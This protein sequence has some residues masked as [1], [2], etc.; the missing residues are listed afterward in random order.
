MLGHSLAASD[1]TIEGEDSSR[2]RDRLFQR[3]IVEDVRVTERLGEQR[4]QLRGQQNHACLDLRRPP[5]SGLVQR[6]R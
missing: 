6:L 4:R 2:W 5:R 3:T 1:D